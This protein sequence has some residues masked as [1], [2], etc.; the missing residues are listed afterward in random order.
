MKPMIIQYVGNNKY[1]GCFSYGN[2]TDT[3]RLIVIKDTW[4]E[5]IEALLNL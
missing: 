3:E 5:V 4:S 1:A 2:D